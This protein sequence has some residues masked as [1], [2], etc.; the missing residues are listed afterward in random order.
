M[1]LFFLIFRKEHTGHARHKDIRSCVSLVLKSYFPVYLLLFN[2]LLQQTT[3]G[4]YGLKN[5][6]AEHLYP[7][8]ILLA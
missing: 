2:V 8:V 7:A 5:I 3:R 6:S 4:V 1:Q